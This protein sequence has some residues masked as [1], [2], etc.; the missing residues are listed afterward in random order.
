MYHWHTLLSCYFTCSA[1]LQHIY[2]PGA[3]AL[4]Y[5]T[6]RVGTDVTS[7]SD[8]WRAMMHLNSSVL[9]PTHHLSDVVARQGSL[10]LITSVPAYSTPGTCLYTTCLLTSANTKSMDGVRSYDIILGD[11]SHILLVLHAMLGCERV[12]ILGFPPVGLVARMGKTGWQGRKTAEGDE[13]DDNPDGGGKYAQGEIR[14]V[15]YIGVENGSR[16]QRGLEAVGAWRQLCKTRGGDTRTSTTNRGS[17]PA[18]ALLNR[19]EE[20][21]KCCH[22]NGGGGTIVCLPRVSRAKVTLTS[23]TNQI[24]N[25]LRA[26]E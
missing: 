23:T 26:L 25:K 17:T 13:D 20:K 21:R 15:L 4:R 7:R 3:D 16:R 24:E 1:S 19:K 9:I 6:V 8:P 11:F 2:K 14:R 22:P 12:I 18:S 5:S 10:R